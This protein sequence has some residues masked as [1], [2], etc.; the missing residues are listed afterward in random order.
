MS[1]ADPARNWDELAADLDEAA[2][3]RAAVY[4]RLAATVSEPDRPVYESLANGGFA[5][6][7]RALV[8]ETGIDVDVPTIETDGDFETTC[9][10]Y[11]DLFH[12]GHSADSDTGAPV[13]PY[14]STYRDDA[15]W[16]EVNVDLARAYDYFGLGVDTDVR[17]HHDHV[18]LELDFAGYLCRLAAAVEDG[19]ARA[20]L[21]FHDRHLA[22]FLE[23]VADR[24]AVQPRPGVY[25][26]LL[27]FAAA[28]AAA[29]RD[30]LNRRCEP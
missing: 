15:S 18:R 22:G 12:V 25:E 5:A 20:R 13:P 23:S 16:N 6:D 11:N 9:A 7:L 30:E 26:P 27:A 10:R 28:F 2:V 14:E 3:A 4:E 24:V 29:D 21:D 8:A 17:E 19:A 1:D